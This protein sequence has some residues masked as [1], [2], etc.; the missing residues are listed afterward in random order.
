MA[1]GGRGKKKACKIEGCGVVANLFSLCV[2]HGGTDP[3]PDSEV[4][5]LAVV[6]AIMNGE[7]PVISPD[8]TSDFAERHG[9]E[10]QDEDKVSLEVPLGSSHAGGTLNFNAALAYS[11]SNANPMP[12]TVSANP[13]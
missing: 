13:S 9:E 10:P 2:E 7:D 8:S 3:M 1:H 4:V 5:P 12:L 11:P 6:Q